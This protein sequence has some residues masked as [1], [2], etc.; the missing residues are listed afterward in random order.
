MKEWKKKLIEEFLGPDDDEI[1]L[2]EYCT[3]FILPFTIVII[4]L[5]LVANIIR[6]A[7]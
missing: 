3:H 5:A 7:K 1:N 6:W 4:L 2:K